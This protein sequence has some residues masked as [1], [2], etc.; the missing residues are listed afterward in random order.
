MEHLFIINPVAGKGKALKFIKEIK[1][2]FVNSGKKYLIKITEKPGHA[3]E[4]AREYTRKGCLRV[5][6]VGGDGTLNEVVNGMVGSNSS[7][8]I[9]PAGSGN[10]FIKSI[11]NSNMEPKDILVRAING[12]KVRLADLAKVNERYFINISSIGFDA[13]V[14]YN[15]NKIKKLPCIP[16]K[17]AYIL[18][19]LITLFKYNN[20]YLKVTIDGQY[21][22]TKSLLT[23]VANG[24]YYGGGMLPTPNAE[25][26]DG[27]FDICLISEVNRFKIFRFLPRFIKG[28]HGNLKE[29]SFYR[30]K[31]ITIE[32]DKDLAIN[33]DGEVNKVRKASFEI[34]PKAISIVVP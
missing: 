8:A 9:I 34:I 31:K 2:L 24:R 17:L 15:T 30:G 4:I 12:S 18:G 11:V 25:I 3:T 20:Y 13:E 10:D 29:V 33:I 5:Y 26:D 1:N 23:A 6:S 27:Q 22:E 19:V 7:L 14:V 28:L 21:I 32:C 16:G